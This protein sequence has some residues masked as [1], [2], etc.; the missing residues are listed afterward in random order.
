[1]YLTV[2]ECHMRLNQIL[3]GYFLCSCSSAGEA[4]NTCTEPN[5]SGFSQRCGFLVF[6]ADIK[7]LF[8]VPPRSFVSLLLLPTPVLLSSPSPGSTATRPVW[9]D[10]LCYHQHPTKWIYSPT[11]LLRWSATPPCLH[12]DTWLLTYT[13]A[14]HGDNR[15]WR[16][17]TFYVCG[18]TLEICKVRVA[19]KACQDNYCKSC[20][21][22]STEGGFSTGLNAGAS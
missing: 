17:V 9:K 19:S 16:D 18:Q 21:H 14:C 13:G 3:N 20:R 7:R 11:G 6:D 12:G 22:Q 15:K 8:T 10:D 2:V 5:S 4:A 1:M